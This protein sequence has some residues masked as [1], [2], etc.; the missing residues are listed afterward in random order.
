MN[1]H[2][3]AYMGKARDAARLARLALDEG[4][5]DGAVSRAYYAAFYAATAA[6]LVAGEAPRT[7]KGVHHRFRLLYVKSGRVPEAIGTLLP[8]ASDMRQKADYDALTVFEARAVADLI[9]DVERFLAAVEPL[10]TDNPNP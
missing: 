6:L 7:H 4:V 10:L 2:A 9:A 5:L 3:A 1:E 8:Y